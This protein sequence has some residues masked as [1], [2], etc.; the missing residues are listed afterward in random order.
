MQG[1]EEEVR[2]GE[3]L[4][5]MDLGIYIYIFLY[6]LL[7]CV[8]KLYIL[9]HVVSSNVFIHYTLVGWATFNPGSDQKDEDL[10]AMMRTSRL[11]RYCIISMSM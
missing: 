11:V 9:Y 6:H 8:H 5:E 2:P 10:T 1:T 4:S 3:Y 7:L